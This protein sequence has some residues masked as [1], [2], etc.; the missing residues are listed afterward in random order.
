MD[1]NTVIR[2]VAS[3]MIA[4]IPFLVELVRR[5]RKRKNPDYL[6]ELLKKYHE[7]RDLKDKHRKSRAPVYVIRKLDNLIRRL[8]NE[9]HS[10]PYVRYTVLDRVSLK[11]FRYLVAAEGFLFLG[12]FFSSDF[13]QI[14]VSSLSFDSEAFFLE[15]IFMNPVMRILFLVL[16]FSVAFFF[17]LRFTRKVSTMVTNQ[18]LLNLALFLVF[19]TCFVVVTFVCSVVF[20]LLD[21]VTNL[22]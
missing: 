20:N 12:A 1:S 18:F 21:P 5:M 4:S 16:L 13:V 22:W 3:F 11:V 6:L 10:L 14:L 15:G 9:I 2:I 17:T 19:N 8:E 7:A